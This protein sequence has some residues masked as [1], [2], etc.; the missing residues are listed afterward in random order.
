V[1]LATASEL[2][3][4]TDLPTAEIAATLG[5]GSQSSF[6]R[7]FRRWTHLSPTRWRRGS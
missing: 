3:S 4:L 5:Y 6:E 2:L 1:S 7:A